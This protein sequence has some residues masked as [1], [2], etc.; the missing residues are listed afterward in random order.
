MIRAFFI[1]NNVWLLADN[2]K[3]KSFYE[4]NKKKVIFCIFSIFFYFLMDITILT[5][6]VNY[7][8]IGVSLL[9]LSY[10]FLFISFCLYCYMTR[11]SFPVFI[12]G[13]TIIACLCFV[14]SLGSD[15]TKTSLYYHANQEDINSLVQMVHEIKREDEALRDQ[16]SEEFYTI[17]YWDMFL[18]EHKNTLA[19]MMTKLHL[20][21][22]K[23]HP[24][25]IEFQISGYSTSHY[26]TISIIKYLTNDTSIINNKCSTVKNSSQLYGSWYYNYHHYDLLSGHYDYWWGVV[27][28]PKQDE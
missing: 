12:S 27:N 13:V 25:Y 18:S 5:L 9:L 15:Y 8:E 2:S 1:F 11:I 21:L 26:E 22:I 4:N 7:L 16:S 14:Y 3:M 6:Q 23:K 24:N 19:S 20:L 17:Y 10:V 28:D